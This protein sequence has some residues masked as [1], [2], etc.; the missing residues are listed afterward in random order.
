MPQGLALSPDGTRLAVVESGVKPA[1]LRILSTPSLQEQNA[2]P[3][4]GA[5]GRPVWLDN[6]HVLVAGANGDA[7]LNV[8]VETKTADRLVLPA[9]SWPAAI[10]VNGNAIAA[11]SDG[12]ASVSLGTLAGFANTVRTGDHPADAIFSRDGKTLYVS[13]R[14]SNS[15]LAIDTQTH[16]V[17]ATIAVGLHPGALALSTDGSALYVAESDDDSIGVIDTR[18]RRVLQHIDVGL[19]ANRLSGYGA[20]PNALLVRGDDLFVALGAQNSVA[21]VRDGRVVER[22]PAGWYPTGIA[23][24]NDGTLYV[25]NGKGESAPPNPQFDP[26]KHEGKWYVGE[27]TTGSVRAIPASVW[28]Q[29]A[30]ESAKTL[31]NAMPLWKTPVHT[32]VRAHGPI[33]H[34][35]YIIKENRS[36]DQVLGDVASANGDAKLAWF[37]KTVTPNQHAIAERFGV[38]DNAYANSQVSAD[39]HNWTD[40]AFANDYVERFWPPTYGDRRNDIYDLQTAAAPDVPHNGYLWDAAKRAHITYRDY[41]EGVD[42]AP[43]SPIRMSINS[44]PGLAGHFD[45][46]YIGWDLKYSDLDRFAEWQR[47][48]RSFVK[49]GDLPQLEIVYLPNDHTAGTKHGELTPQAYVAINDFAV[50]KLVDEVSHSRYWKSTAIFVVE[51]DAQNGPDHVSDQRSTFYVASAY[52]PG[53]VHHTHYS[54]VSVVRTIELLLGLPALSIYDATAAPM[55]DAFGTSAANAAAYTVIKP[56][57]NTA[58]RNGKAAYGSAISARLDFSKPDAVDPQV[59]N[60]ILAHAARRR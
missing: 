26:T 53:G 44:F 42:E 57:I 22:I 38:F 16:A 56:R 58:A 25:S 28:T 9:H 8:D 14:Q 27:L 5:F 46:R 34:A 13:V 10:A 17:I 29:A 49:N 60:D 1:T 51:D 32:I 15:V 11:V 4:T 31:S 39:G 48:F 37:G 52:A 54:T 2:I 50:G 59:M 55:Y 24:G 36:Y 45:P 47:E 7:V 30:A 41:G 43:H 40:A 20:S 6:G 35:I 18:S 21:L 3:L 23:L 12:T 33:Q 19:H